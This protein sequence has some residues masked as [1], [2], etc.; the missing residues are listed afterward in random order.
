M[1]NFFLPINTEIT[2]KGVTYD[3]SVPDKS[4]PR[5]AKKLG[6]GTFGAVFVAVQ[7]GT[8]L[9]V[10]VKVGSVSTQ[11]Q[12]Q[13]FKS[14][15]RMNELF[16]SAPNCNPYIICL[17]NSGVQTIAGQSRGL[18]IQRL[19]QG[20]LGKFVNRDLPTTPEV[21][22]SMI[23]SNIKAVS[24]LHSQGCAHRDIKTGNILFTQ[25]GGK[26]LIQ[27]ADLGLSC[28]SPT[29]PTDPFLRKCVDFGGS[30]FSPDHQQYVRERKLPPMSTY[31]GLDMWCLGIT[32]LSVIIHGYTD[33]PLKG[34]DVRNYTKDLGNLSPETINSLVNGCLEVDP[35]KRL[36]IA[37]AEK[38]L[39][40]LV[41]K[42]DD[43]CKYADTVIN[44]A[45][46]EELV[47]FVNL[48]QGEKIDKNLPTKELCTEIADK[49]VINS[50]DGNWRYFDKKFVSQFATGMTQ[51]LGLKTELE[52]IKKMP[53]KKGLEVM[54]GFLRDVVNKQGSATNK[55]QIIDLILQAVNTLAQ[56][57]TNHPEELE[58]SLMRLADVMKPEFMDIE[59][60]KLK[61]Q[62]YRDIYRNTTIARDRD[63]AV[64]AENILDKFVE[65]LGKPE[66]ALRIYLEPSMSSRP[67]PQEIELPDYMEIS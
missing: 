42:K 33:R 23:Y 51:I 60:L 43:T 58:E 41:K 45:N 35:Q 61:M 47:D 36:K 9:R 54:C 27:I 59:Y 26:T 46:V 48:Y 28:T 16:S 13:E 19:M 1:E 64:K 12:M 34:F 55:M 52:A 21:L 37:D 66:I 8:E 29:D 2:L 39:K 17:L 5:K 11:Q 6:S 31:F 22:H 30:Y 40:S 65:H 18:M 20:D 67:R 3:L 32:W 62:E 56:G 15:V 7:R 50:R 24:F 10:A 25:E 44:R 38:L 63:I 14:E 57:Q 4:D 53:P 49:C